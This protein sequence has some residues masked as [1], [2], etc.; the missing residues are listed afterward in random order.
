MPGL[1]PVGLPS[2]CAAAEVVFFGTLTT[3]LIP[4]ASTVRRNCT[5]AA[6]IV[7]FAMLAAA[8]YSNSRFPDADDFAAWILYVVAGF[9]FALQNL[10]YTSLGCRVNAALFGLV[11]G[12]AIVFLAVVWGRSDDS[13]PMHAV[14]VFGLAWLGAAFLLLWRLPKDWRLFAEPEN[15]EQPVRFQFTL[16]GLLAGV[17]AV[18]MVLGLGRAM[19]EWVRQDRLFV[20]N[21]RFRAELYALDSELAWPRFFGKRDT[22]A[23][24]GDPIVDR[25]EYASPRCRGTVAYLQ[26]AGLNFAEMDAFEAVVFW[27][28]L[29]PLSERSGFLTD[30]T[31]A[32]LRRPDWAALLREGCVYGSACAGPNLVDR[33]GDGWPEYIFHGWSDGYPEKVFR[34]ED[35]RIVA[36][37]TKSDRASGIRRGYFLG[38][39]RELKS[40]DVVED[41][42]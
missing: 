35:G 14:L 24:S 18:A 19:L 6:P 11:F 26:S 20:D 25:L 15:P 30:G 31:A 17:A 34:L 23:P 9:F 32:R 16:R 7:V 13:A 8:W 10:R 33:D 1:N 12:A 2:I 27:L 40:F 38:E 22:L 39:D 36:W 42:P 28:T 41:P 37:D 4:V 29:G 21:M 3:G 5:M